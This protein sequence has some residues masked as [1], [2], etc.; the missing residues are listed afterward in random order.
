ML[1]MKKQTLSSFSFLLRYVQVGVLVSLGF[2]AS[3][4]KEDATA[5]QAEKP[6]PSLVEQYKATSKETAAN[7]GIA[8]SPGK[9]DEEE[10]KEK[11]H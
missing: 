6:A 2:L 3:C 11:S 4:T 8:G 9:M 1:A 7:P 5:P 10:K